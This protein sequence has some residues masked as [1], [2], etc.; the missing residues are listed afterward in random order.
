MADPDE[1]YIRAKVIKADGDKIDLE[2]AKGNVSVYVKKYMIN[3]VTSQKYYI[4]QVKE[5]SRGAF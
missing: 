2:T 1:V 5:S 4:F 3:A